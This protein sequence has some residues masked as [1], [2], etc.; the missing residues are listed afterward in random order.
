[1]T[2]DN[3]VVGVFHDSACKVLVN[4][5]RIAT[6]YNLIYT[7]RAESSGDKRLYTNDDSYVW[8]DY[9]RYE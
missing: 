8:L 1:M 9:A 3:E 2:K 4:G 6:I 5:E 7:G